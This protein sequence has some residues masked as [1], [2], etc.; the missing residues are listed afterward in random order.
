MSWRD[1]E[2]PLELVLGLVGIFLDE[3]PSE[4]DVLLLLLK[5]VLVVGEDLVGLVS[6]LEDVPQARLVVFH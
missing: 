3:V 2:R 1:T 4:L 6:V 5:Q